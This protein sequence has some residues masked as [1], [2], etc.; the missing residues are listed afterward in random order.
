[1]IVDPEHTSGRP[2]SAIAMAAVEGGAAAIQLRDKHAQRD[3]LLNS[4]VEISEICHNSDVVFIVNDHPEIAA[5]AEAHGVH[6]GQGDASVTRCREVLQGH[7]IVGKSNALVEEARASVAEGADYIAV[8][9]MFP[10]STK[11]DTR[12]AGLETLRLV[13]AQTVVPVVAIGGINVTNVGKVA[14]SGA[15]VVC[16]ATAITLSED[17]A[18]AVHMLLEAFSK[19]RQDRL[20]SEGE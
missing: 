1:M 2:V 8:G 6:V 12:P 20:A 15:D 17:P 11:S 10:T 3:E 19:E 5:D 16:V 13:A 14:A 4:A 18:S 7:Q 9:S